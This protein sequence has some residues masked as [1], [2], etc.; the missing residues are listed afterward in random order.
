MVDNDEDWFEPD[1]GSKRS[2]RFENLCKQLL[3]EF[4]RLN[5]EYLPLLSD[6]MAMEHRLKMV[7]EVATT[8]AADTMDQLKAKLERVQQLAVLCCEM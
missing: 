4:G 5:Q 7:R 2:R 1:I 6:R 3:E 8:D